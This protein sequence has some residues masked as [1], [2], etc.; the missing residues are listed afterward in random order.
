MD[1]AGGVTWQELAVIG[2][3]LSAVFTA[4]W[5][6]FGAIKRQFETQ[7]ERF[8][9]QFAAQATQAEMRT[10]RTHERIEGLGKEMRETFVPRDLFHAEIRRFDDAIDERD[11]QINDMA[12]RLAR[13]AD[14]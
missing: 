1:S 9:K 3:I 2:A 7:T 5:Y 13:M 4:A 8:E 14:R 12:D 10:L 6:I 11:R